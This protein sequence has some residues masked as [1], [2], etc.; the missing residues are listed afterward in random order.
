MCGRYIH[1]LTW[2][3][4]VNLYRL[5]LPGRSTR[6]D[7]SRMAPTYRDPF[8]SRR[9]LVPA[10]GWYE[11][12][13]IDAKRKRPYHMLPKASPF[14]FAGVYD[15]WKGDGGRAITGFAIVVT[16]AAPSIAKIHDRMPV[17]LD[18]AQFDEWTRGTPGQAAALMKPYAGEMEIWEI[19]ADVGSVRN[20]RPE[21][22]ERMG[23]L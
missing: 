5:T 14:A 22:L 1:L 23:L 18:D 2:Q 16:D 8:R 3:Q 10:S 4:I 11:W 6:A 19:G 7:R 17:V 9:C 21:L 20:N 13:K 15:V 12:Q